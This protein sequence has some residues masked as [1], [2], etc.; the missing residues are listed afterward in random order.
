VGS[1]SVPLIR[2]EQDHTEQEIS[3]QPADS[4]GEGQ[5]SSLQVSCAMKRLP[6]LRAAAS[7]VEQRACHYCT[8]LPA[9]SGQVLLQVLGF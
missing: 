3:V 7:P 6:A 2:I 8:Q 5:I 9:R 4:F 1:A